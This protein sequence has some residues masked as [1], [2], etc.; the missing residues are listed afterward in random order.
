V[1]FSDVPFKRR[2]V[3]RTG[4]VFKKNLA[5]GLVRSVR[6]ESFLDEGAPQ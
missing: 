5:K 2:A 3:Q 1:P 6:N 4:Y